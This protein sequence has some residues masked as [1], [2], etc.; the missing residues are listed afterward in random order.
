[1][2]FEC[3]IFFQGEDHEVSANCYI[4]SDGIGRTWTA[5]EDIEG[6][7]LPTLTQAMEYHVAE[8]IAE[9]YKNQ[10]DPRD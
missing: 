1:M 9:K 2:R 7:T 8:L 4:D 5:V 3:T 10:P 6:P